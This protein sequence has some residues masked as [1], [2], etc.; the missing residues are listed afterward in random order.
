MNNFEW[1]R[2]RLLDRKGIFDPP[3]KLPDFATLQKTQWSPTFEQL[4][5]NRLLMGAF[6]YGLL[7]RQDLKYDTASDAKRRIDLY[8]S[9]GNTEHLVDAANMCLVEF[10]LG[11]HPNKHFEAQ[12]RG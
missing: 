3:Q 9:T 1:M 7:E 5:R 6:R 10:E 11:K 12:D 2:K 8:K 4:M